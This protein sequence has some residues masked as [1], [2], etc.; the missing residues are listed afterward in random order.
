MNFV[1][2]DHE[3]DNLDIYPIL[4]ISMVLQNISLMVLQPFGSWPIFFSV[5]IL[6]RV[7][8][9]PSTGHQ[10]VARPLCTHDNTNT[11]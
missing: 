4:L 5:L 3:S 7:G 6:Y 1:S 2:N 9:T 10:A 11:E 8:S